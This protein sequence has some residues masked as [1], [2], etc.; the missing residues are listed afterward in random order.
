[1]KV[2]R[3]VLITCLLLVTVAFLAGFVKRKKS[4]AVP[5]TPDAEMEGFTFHTDFAADAGRIPTVDE[6]QSK[7]EEILVVKPVSRTLTQ[8]MDM[9]TTA[10][11]TKTVQSKTGLQKGDRIR[12]YEPSLYYVRDASKPMPGTIPEPGWVTSRYYTLPMCQQA[13]Y[14][15]FLISPEYPEEYH[16]SEL[17]AHTFLYAYPSASAFSTEHGEIYLQQADNT[18][19]SPAEKELQELLVRSDSAAYQSR[20]RELQE[21]IMQEIAARR[22]TWKDVKAYGFI[23]DNEAAKAALETLITEILKRYSF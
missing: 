5:V 23:T 6:L 22:V 15:V 9:L 19:P 10:E 12:I 17:A 14:L 2:R 21:Q 4:P 13:E 16:Q 11:V 1:M 18:E 8:N 3:T 7:A 20:I